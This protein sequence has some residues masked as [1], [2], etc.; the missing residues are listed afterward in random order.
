[1]TTAE[2][3]AT[4]NDLETK[5]PTCEARLQIGYRR[6]PLGG[7]RYIIHF[8]EAAYIATASVPFLFFG[9]TWGYA[10]AFGFASILTV[11]GHLCL[12]IGFIPFL[13]A[14]WYDD[15]TFCYRCKSPIAPSQPAPEKLQ[16]TPNQLGCPHCGAR[17]NL[18]FIDRRNQVGGIVILFLLSSLIFLPVLLVMPVDWAYS[19]ISLRGF[20]ARYQRESIGLLMGV[21]GIPMLLSMLVGLYLPRLAAWLDDDEDSCYYCKRRFTDHPP[22]AKPRPARRPLKQRRSGWQ[23][24][25]QCPNCGINIAWARLWYRPKPNSCQERL[26]NLSLY[27]LLFFFL[28]PFSFWLQEPLF[29]N[30]EK[31]FFFGYAILLSTVGLANLIYRWLRDPINSCPRCQHEYYPPPPEVTPINLDKT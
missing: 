9:P 3:L 8:I 11:L 29:G 19:G 24:V 23:N 31:V 22:L 15:Y 1:M 5:C 17:R 20:F 25:K 2:P 27:L 28:A 14:W 4:S 10:K 18:N 16:A 13:V 30:V 12:L 21:M 6:W 7:L 26:F